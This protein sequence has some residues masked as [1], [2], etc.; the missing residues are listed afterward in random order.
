MAAQEKTRTASERQHARVK[1]N[2]PIDV[3]VSRFLGLQARC[4][5]VSKGGMR[6]LV[7]DPVRVGD[8]LVFGVQLPGA[9]DFKIQAQVRHVSENADGHFEI[10]LAWVDVDDRAAS[11]FESLARG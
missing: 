4:L 5:D 9:P 10:G 2:R 11:I 8:C 7:E 6:L 3:R 1:T